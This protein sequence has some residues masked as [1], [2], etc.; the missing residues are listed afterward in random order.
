MGE[1]YCGVPLMRYR[2]GMNRA[3]QS[4]ACNQTNAG[5][6]LATLEKRYA[7]LLQLRDEV[8]QLS[9]RLE[10]LGPTKPERLAT[11]VE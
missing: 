9:C 8:E 10:Q 2:S 7:K 5:R 6:S 1:F 4:S 11:I 3:K